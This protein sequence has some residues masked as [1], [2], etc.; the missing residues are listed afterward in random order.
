MSLILPIATLLRGW[1]MLGLVVGL[2]DNRVGVLDRA[3]EQPP[4]WP[5]KRS[6][7]GI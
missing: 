1:A 2:R 6:G 4:D 3:L 5:W 7:L